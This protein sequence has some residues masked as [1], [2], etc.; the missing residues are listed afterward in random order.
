MLSKSARRLVMQSVQQAG[1]VASKARS[2]MTFD[3]AGPAW[4]QWHACV[5]DSVRRIQL[6][7]L[8]LR[9]PLTQHGNADFIP[10]F[11]G[12]VERAA[13][14]GQLYSDRSCATIQQFEP[15]GAVSRSW[16]A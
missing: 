6:H 8:I 15:P 4:G 9:R 7:G 10:G 11:P 14:D 13:C 5:R 12:T 16:S 1:R 2:W 3:I